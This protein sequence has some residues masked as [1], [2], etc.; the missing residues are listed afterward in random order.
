MSVY[1]DIDWS[2]TKHDVCVVNEAGTSVAALVLPYTAPWAASL[3][4]CSSP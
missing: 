1:I 3:F 2:A 4:L